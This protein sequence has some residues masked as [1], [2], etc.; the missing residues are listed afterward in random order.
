MDFG[1]L[2]K[3]FKQKEVDP[4]VNESM[5]QTPPRRDQS[6]IDKTPDDKRNPDQSYADFTDVE[7]PNFDKILEKRDQAPL[8]VKD[9]DSEEDIDKRSM[10]KEAEIMA[11]KRGKFLSE[12]RKVED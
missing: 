9:S 2:I 12:Q 8:A 10:K 5:T 6:H 11:Q 3:D 7:G 4:Q 1:F